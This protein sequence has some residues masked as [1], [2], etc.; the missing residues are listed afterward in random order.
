MKLWR[1]CP[2]LIHRLP[3]FAEAFPGFPGVLSSSQ[4]SGTGIRDR[5]LIPEGAGSPLWGVYLFLTI[6]GYFGHRL[7]LTVI[8]A[9]LLAAF[10]YF[11]AVL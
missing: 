9:L 7:A 10:G 5:S 3:R 2:Q 8:F 1:V 11:L 6:S 4:T